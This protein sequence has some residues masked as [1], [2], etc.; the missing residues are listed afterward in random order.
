MIIVT[1]A[2]LL[3]ALITAPFAIIPNHGSYHRFFTSKLLWILVAE[4]LTIVYFYWKL[5]IKSHTYRSY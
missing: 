3:D 1:T 5:K 4:N 2:L